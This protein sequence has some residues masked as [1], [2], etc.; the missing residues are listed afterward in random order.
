MA[1]SIVGEFETRDAIDASKSIRLQIWHPRVSYIQECL[2][3]SARTGLVARQRRLARE[4][5]EEA[6]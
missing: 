6:P 5:P 4:A 1:E 2:P 3:F